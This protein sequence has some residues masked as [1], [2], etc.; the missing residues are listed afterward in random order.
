M[1]LSIHRESF[2]SESNE[3]LILTLTQYIIE[4]DMNGDALSYGCQFWD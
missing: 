4:N 2:A 3:K 1:V